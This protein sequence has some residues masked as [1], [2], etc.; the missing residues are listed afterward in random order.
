M[1]CVS[2]SDPRIL[3]LLDRGG[4]G[5]KGRLTGILCTRVIV[6]KR[7][8]NLWP[9]YPGFAARWDYF[10]DSVF[11]RLTRN[12]DLSNRRPSK[13]RPLCI[14]SGAGTS[15]ETK[16]GH[17][18]L[19]VDYPAI[20]AIHPQSI[21]TAEWRNVAVS[22][23]AKRNRGTAPGASASPPLLAARQGAPDRPGVC[24]RPR[25]VADAGQ[26]RAIE[27]RPASTSGAS[28]ELLSSQNVR[29]L[30]AEQQELAASATP[31]DDA[32]T[33]LRQFE[34]PGR[35][36]EVAPPVTRRHLPSGPLAD[37]ALPAW[38]VEVDPSVPAPRPLPRPAEVADE[39]PEAPESVPNLD[40]R[41]SH[42]VADIVTRWPYPT[43]VARRVQALAAR[44]SYTA[45]AADLLAECERLHALDALTAPEVPARLGRLRALAQQATQ[46]AAAEAS[47]NVR[48]ELQRVSYGLSRRLGIWEQVS[49]I[50]S[51]PRPALTNVRDARALPEFLAAA[52]RRLQAVAN[53]QTWREYLLLD[54]AQRDFARARQTDTTECRTLA[55]R[56]LLR[57]DFASLTPAEGTFLQQPEL[58]A[59]A[60]ELKQLATEPVDYLRLLDEIERY[61]SE[62]TS[63][64]AVQAAAAQQTLRWSP[65]VAVVDLAAAG[66]ALP[67]CQRPDLGLETVH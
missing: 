50:A 28:Q 16:V 62:R 64:H 35:V 31:S 21:G 33:A 63:D 38:E 59:L 1:G 42:S 2:E 13:P 25:R 55:K 56:I 57:M 54:E 23:V 20:G 7:G 15:D 3:C 36:L 49:A 11:T 27:P 29:P 10:D 4:P 43:A 60:A 41:E 39:A 6:G 8:R 65:N 5:V 51:Q 12:T 52:S 44:P 26:N 30:I 46:L 24:L 61:E 32:L 45:W 14:H 18:H 53:G 34:M 37:I 9:D 67:Q 40:R 19:A 22:P 48:V 47:V 17:P 66:R 58:A